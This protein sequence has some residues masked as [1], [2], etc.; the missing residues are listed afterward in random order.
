PKDSEI[1]DFIIHDII[2]LL[3]S[4]SGVKNSIDKKKNKTI[5]PKRLIRLAVTEIKNWEFPTNLMR[6]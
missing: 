1:L 6:C 4:T 2:P 5:N 3:N